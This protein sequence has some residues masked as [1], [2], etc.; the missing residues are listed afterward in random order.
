MR[1]AQSFPQ[2]SGEVKVVLSPSRLGQQEK[3][4]VLWLASAAGAPIAR[5]SPKIHP[6]RTTTRP[7]TPQ[8]YVHAARL[9]RDSESGEWPARLD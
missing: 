6:R 5:R 3:Q 8:E 4:S 2:Q 7:V 1:E 9:A